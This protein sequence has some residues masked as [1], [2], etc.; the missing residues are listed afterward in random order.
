[1]FN[2]YKHRGKKDITLM[3]TTVALMTPGDMGHAIGAV[4]VKHGIDVITCLKGRSDRSIALSTKAGIRAVDSDE[5]L[6]HQSSILLSVLVPSHAYSLAERM[7]KAVKSLPSKDWIY[8]DLNAISPSTTKSIGE[9]FEGTRVKYVDG[10]IIGPPPRYDGTIG[11]PTRIHVSGEHAPEVLI[12]N[13]YGLTVYNAGPHIGQASA[14]KMCFASIT[15]GLSAIAI[16]SL[17]AGEYLGL[18]D[19]LY[20]ELQESNPVVF[21][22][23]KN[24]IPVVGPKAYRWVGEMQEIGKTFKEVGMTDKMFEGAAE[25]FSFV[26][27]TPFGKE[28]VENRTCGKTLENAVEIMAQ[29]LKK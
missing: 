28:V 23:L 10:G 13:Q 21:N 7:V 20:T 9:L 6:V 27:H 3:K 8:V 19:K 14:L 15:K 1:M 16:Q 17:T 18:G 22:V 5:D 11:K 12:L 26:E 4:L 29:S 24:S 25:V 2:T